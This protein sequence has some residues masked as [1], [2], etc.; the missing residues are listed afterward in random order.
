MLRFS[1]VRRAHRQR[2]HTHSRNSSPS[3]WRRPICGDGVGDVA[4]TLQA[5]PRW[6]GAL[7][8]WNGQQRRAC[9]YQALGAKGARLAADLC[10]ETDNYD[11]TMLDQRFGD[12]SHSSSRAL[13]STGVTS[14]TTKTSCTSS[15]SCVSWPT[16]ASLAPVGPSIFEI[17]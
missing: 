4:E 12:R 6:H 1:Q 9:L 3:T 11:E 7:N 2:D 15:R 17:V 10:P 13:S 5:A 14:T 8:S 16:A